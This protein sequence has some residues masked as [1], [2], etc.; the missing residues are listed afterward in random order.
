MS[1]IEFNIELDSLT[2]DPSSEIF[3]SNDID[4]KILCLNS[5]KPAGPKK[6]TVKWQRVHDRF[7]LNSYQGSKILYL[8]S[9]GGKP[10]RRVVST[11]ELFDTLE[12]LHKIEA[13][14]T[15]RTRLYKRASQEFYGITE[16]ICGIFV[17]TCP[18]CY[19]KKSKKS[20]KS[21]VVKPIS[22]TEYH[23]R[24]QVDLVDMSD[25]NLD[26]NLSPDGVTPY[27]YLLVYLDHFTKKV[28][29]APL[30]RKCAEE[31]TE[32]LLDIFCDAGPPHILHSDNGREFKNEILFSTLSEKWPTLKIIHGKP[33]H[34]ESQGAVERANRDIKD[35]LFTAMHDNSNDQCWVKYLRWVQLHK[36]ISYHTTIRM[37]PYEAVYNKK[38]SFGLAHFG[39][40]HE[41]WNQINTEQDLSD[42]QNEINENT[43]SEE[44]ESSTDSIPTSDNE[45]PP[46]PPSK[47]PPSTDFYHDEISQP[48]PHGTIVGEDLDYCHP[49]QSST[50]LI[51][52]LAIDTTIPLQVSRPI[53]SGTNKNCVACG[54]LTSG[55][56]SCPRCHYYIHSY[57]GRLEREET[58]YL[59]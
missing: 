42:Y 13:D 40:P 21:I 31:V 43:V 39:V 56:H 52:D 5:R 54:K 9:K 2:K 55:A 57:C 6:E 10:A 53:A 29:L 59:K 16:K 51:P 17:K 22:S 46:S 18:V 34:P 36:N 25:L 4:N 3:S 23:C 11:D 35:A 58:H 32:V 30:K 37:S 12:R 27:K 14:H 38:P 24:G 45:F 8:K 15:G 20:L 41:H 1:R 50:C 44:N 49:I 48:I 47:F 28:N 33:R 7:M 19:L 26:A